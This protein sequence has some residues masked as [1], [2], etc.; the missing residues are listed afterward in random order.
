MSVDGHVLSVLDE[1]NNVLSEDTS[2]WMSGHSFEV[3][4]DFPLS[5]AL[6]FGFI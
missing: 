6:P 3:F 2:I 5:L 4:F 1:N